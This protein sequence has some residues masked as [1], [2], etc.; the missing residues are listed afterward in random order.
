MG[1]DPRLGQ[2]PDGLREGVEPGDLEATANAYEAFCCGIIDAVAPLVPAVKPQI[3][4]YELYGARGFEVYEQTVRYAQEKGLIVIGDAKRNDIG[5]TAA[6]Y[7]AGHL[8]EAPLFS[9]QTRTVYTDWL[10]VN[11]YLGEDGLKPFLEMC[12]DHGKGIFVLVKTSNPS[13]GQFQ[14][15]TL[16]DVLALVR[17]YIWADKYVKS[18]HGTGYVLFPIQKWE[19]ILDL[20]AAAA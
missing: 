11:P 14:D 19:A 15:V 13:S 9:S 5:S 3:A 20:L 16:S 10:T 12:Q 8:G 4:F 7:A 18:I 2:L 1:L 17:R 6:A